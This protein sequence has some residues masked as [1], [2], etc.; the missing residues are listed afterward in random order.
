MNGLSAHE[1][2][3]PFHTRTQRVGGQGRR[4]LDPRLPA[5]WTVRRQRLLGDSPPAQ[6][7]IPP[8][9]RQAYGRAPGSF[10]P[11]GPSLAS[12]CLVNKV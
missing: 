9:R 11:P 2:R 1:L 6:T 4:H 10:S 8:Q 3:C 7:D 12:T 5:S